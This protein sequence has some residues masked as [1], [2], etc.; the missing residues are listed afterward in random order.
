MPLTCIY[1]QTSTTRKYEAEVAQLCIRGWFS[2]YFMAK[3]PKGI[4]LT[5][6]EYM[7]RTT[8]APKNPGPLRVGNRMLDD[9]LDVLSDN[10]RRFEKDADYRK[11]DVIGISEFADH[12][13]LLEV[14]I[15][16][17]WRSAAT[18]VHDKLDTLRNT[19]NKLLSRPAQWEASAWKP[20]RVSQSM[21]PTSGARWV[22]FEPTHR[23]PPPAGV[24][25]YE[26]HSLNPDEGK[27]P[28]VQPTLTAFDSDVDSLL[29][30]VKKRLRKA[31][32]VY[33]PGNSDYVIIMPEK[34]FRPFRKRAM[35]RA[36]QSYT[37]DGAD[38]DFPG[39]HQLHAINHSAIPAM[40]FVVAGALLTVVTA[41]AG[42]VAIV[43]AVPAEVGVGLGTGAGVEATVAIEATETLR[44]T[45]AA[46]N[47]A[48][49]ANAEATIAARALPAALANAA[50]AAAPALRQ[51][52]A[53]A[54][55]VCGLKLLEGSARA[56][57]PS[58]NTGAV[59]VV[60]VRHFVRQSGTP[61]ANSPGRPHPPG[62]GILEP[63]PNQYPQELSLGSQVRFDGIFQ[64][65]IAHVSV[66]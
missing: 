29:P 43:V 9:L 65:V 38:Y 11:F 42:D 60:P 14:T 27:R 37:R 50:R 51:A 7:A 4:V 24:I 36:M 45:Q 21:I 44:T 6:L 59:R 58:D 47:A 35:Q 2:T 30:V 33:D 5:E 13:E 3:H 48:M 26:V 40:E 46:Y 39:G 15:E 54:G 63:P 64:I 56:D 61:S 49:V 41:G 17:N 12:G 25:L 32:P 62:F 31:I 22:C 8:R 55:V 66:R 1:P 34:F 52:T 19:I 28:T 53:A 23:T 57:S 16:D 10:F 18:Q 20:N